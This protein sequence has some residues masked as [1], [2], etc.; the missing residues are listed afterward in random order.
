[1][2]VRAAEQGFVE[3]INPAARVFDP[4]LRGGVCK[5]ARNAFAAVSVETASTNEAHVLRLA[6]LRT[7]AR[8]VPPPNDIDAVKQAFEAEQILFPKRARTFWSVTASVTGFVLVAAG[9]LAFVFMFPS[10]RDRFARSALGEAMSDGLTD[11]TVGISRHD[12]PREEKGRA[13]IMTRAVKRQIGDKGF[14]L[15]GTALDQSKALSSAFSA[16]DV[17]REQD[18][19]GATLHALDAELQTKKLPAFLD[20]Y[21]EG[22]LMRGATNVWLLGYYVDDRATLTVG[23][24]TVPMLRGRRLDNL[25]LDIGG[26]SYESKALGGWIISIDEIEAWVV[27]NVV[28]ALGKGHGFAFGEHVAKEEGSEG[29]LAA[30]VG[31]RIRGDLLARAALSEDDATE[32]ADLLSQRHTAFVRLAVLGDELY[33]PRGLLPKPHLTKALSRRKDLEMDAR[34]ITRIEDRL[35]RFDKSFDRLVAAQAA[36]EE[37]R[38]AS[39]STCRKTET[40]TRKAEPELVMDGD[41]LFDA[42]TAA[43]SSRLM[44][45][46][47]ADTTYLALAEAEM[48]PGGYATFFLLERELGLS[49]DWLAPGGVKD[50]AEHGQL[51]TALFD[52]PAADIRKAAESVYAKVFGAP[53]PAVIRTAAPR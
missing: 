1:V 52:K 50:D 41:K 23:T 9:V 19:L 39:D 6:F 42:K 40:C 43:V 30:K 18:A 21:V 28:P 11:W 8:P 35:S 46:G 27:F 3:A 45:V 49:P 29:R 38:V 31:E 32:L 48:G 14:D 37:I 25:N 53:M 20:D 2:L 5:G 4:L 47:R 34:E 15:L 36:L 26:T 16:E 33:E 17:K 13:V 22:N 24:E 12:F 7:G 44:M 51:G 10:A